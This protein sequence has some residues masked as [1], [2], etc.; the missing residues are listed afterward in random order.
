MNRAHLGRCYLECA[1]HLVCLSDSRCLNWFS[2]SLEYNQY[3]HHHFSSTSS[4]AHK[5]PSN[6]ELRNSNLT[7]ITHIPPYPYYL[8]S[9]ERGFPPRR[10]CRPS[11]PKDMKWRND[12][13][14][15]TPS[16]DPWLP[17]AS[18]ILSSCRWRDEALLWGDPCL[19]VGQAIGGI[20]WRGERAEHP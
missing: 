8:L 9:C 10:R 14:S 17:L 18:T 15:C 3:G 19:A 11:R 7:A 2:S 4:L 16:L 20:A 6:L 12:N 1:R 13:A 5:F